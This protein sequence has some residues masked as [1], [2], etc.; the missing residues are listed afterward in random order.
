MQ[1]AGQIDAN[2]A[3]LARR[4][5]APGVPCGGVNRRTEIQLVPLLSHIRVCCCCAAAAA[6]GRSRGDVG[7]IF[8]HLAQPETQLAAA[9]LSARN[10]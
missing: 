3:W 7:G 5:G 2:I 1:N 4:R 10:G 6:A 8:G 9:T